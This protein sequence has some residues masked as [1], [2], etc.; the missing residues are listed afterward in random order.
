MDSSWLQAAKS[1]NYINR[2]VTMV[3]YVPYKACFKIRIKH[4][5]I[6]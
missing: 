2:F 1:F 3:K 6:I 4:S 5:L